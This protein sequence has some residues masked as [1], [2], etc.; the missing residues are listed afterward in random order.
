MEKNKN[1]LSIP[2][3]DSCWGVCSDQEDGA[4]EVISTTKLRQSN[5]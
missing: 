1:C 3:P 2:L 5:L 4:V